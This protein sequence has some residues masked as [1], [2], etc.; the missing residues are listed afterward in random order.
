MFCHSL[1]GSV[2]S[3]TADRRYPDGEPFPMPY[4]YSR[5]DPAGQ[6]Y[7]PQNSRRFERRSPRIPLPNAPQR[8]TYPSTP[9][10][11]AG[12][13]HLDCSSPACTAPQALRR[14]ARPVNFLGAARR[15]LWET[16]KIRSSRDRISHHG[17]LPYSQSG[18]KTRRLKTLRYPGKPSGR[19][20]LHATHRNRLG[21]IPLVRHVKRT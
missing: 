17:N 12:V 15:G 21:A 1:L 11:I 3:R 5:G 8:R 6:D 18:S 7:P 16:Q 14:E 19:R 13:G 9:T 4:G 20:H 2:R 10:G